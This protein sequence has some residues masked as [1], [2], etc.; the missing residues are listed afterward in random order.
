MR[1][2]ATLSVLALAV[3]G[4]SDEAGERK[5]GNEP[6][7]SGQVRLAGG[8]IEA[9]RIVGDRVHGLGR[10]G[11]TEKLVGPINTTFLA[12][13]TPV[14]VPDPSRREIAYSAF[15]RKS[16]V[17]RLLDVQTNEDTILARGAY[18]AAWRSDRA[19]AYFQA[20]QPDVP[21][22]IKNYVGHVVVRRSPGEPAVRWTAAP[23]I[24]VVGAWAGR[25]LLVYRIARRGF[26]DLLVFDGPR[27][28]RKLAASGALIAVSPDGSKAFVS[29]YGTARPVVRVVRIADGSELARYMLPPATRRQRPGRA[30]TFV[31]E[32]GSW[33]RNIVVAPV[34]Y[35]VAVFRVRPRRIVLEQVLRFNPGTFPVGVVEPRLDDSARRITAWGQLVPLPREAIPL[36]AVVE[37]DRRTL[38]CARGRRVSSFPGPR[39]VYNPSRP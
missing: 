24:Y 22:L 12:T 7:R 5:R 34:S 35:G 37:C 14:A 13:L 23:G 9:P 18:S 21:R 11:T 27:R 26:P 36:A 4:C 3:A 25:R 32:S 1:I 19:L 8:S 38:R 15:D 33:T 28:V 10:P 31:S 39:I 6:F 20:L 2:A 30:I 17:V 29:R 16:P